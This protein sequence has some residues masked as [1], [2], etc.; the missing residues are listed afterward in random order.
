[1]PAKN[2]A[3]SIAVFACAAISAM[4]APEGGVEQFFHPQPAATPLRLAGSRVGF[5][6]FCEDILLYPFCEP[7]LI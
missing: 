7:I 6:D 3:R 5:I 2:G 4:V 1:M